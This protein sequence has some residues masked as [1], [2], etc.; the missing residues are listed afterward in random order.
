[1]GL[2][3][4]KKQQTRQ[5][6]LSV[7]SKLFDQQG[8]QVTTIDEIAAQAKISRMTFFNYFAGKDKLLEAL[9]IDLFSQHRSLF[10]IMVGDEG[11]L[12][13]VAPPDLD[14]RLDVIITH[15]KL[16]KMVAQHTQLFNNFA[17]STAP[18]ADSIAP[19]MESHFQNRLNRVR[20]AQQ[21][22]VIRDDIE[23]TEVCHLYDALRN[24][25]VG[26]WLLDDDASPNLLKQRF[27]AAM[28]VFQLG[29]KR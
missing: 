2:R 6:L 21:Q 14:E 1:M 16:L 12:G 4:Q 8:F 17:L 15:R 3:E 25:I 5:C 24:D 13:A 19:Y 28:R 23:A 29:L 27:S 10:E 18:S 11:T 9:A 20:E 7:A 26:R 22:G